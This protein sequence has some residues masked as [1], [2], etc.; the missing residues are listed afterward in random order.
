MTTTI[1]PALLE[2]IKSLSLPLDSP[3]WAELSHAFGSAAE[4]PTDLKALAQNEGGQEK[5]W[6]ELWT[7]LCHQGTVYTASFA[8][9]PH[10]VEM[11]LNTPKEDRLQLIVLVAMIERG[12]LVHNGAFLPKVSET[13]YFASL[14][15]LGEIILDCL[16][17]IW[18]ESEYKA[19]FMSLATIRGEVDLG[20]AIDFLDK[21]IQCP[22]CE[23][24]LVMDNY[25][26]ADVVIKREG[27]REFIDNGVGYLQWCEDHPLGFIVRVPLETVP[28]QYVLHRV[29]CPELQTEI[30]GKHMNLCYMDSNL[31]HTWFYRYGIRITGNVRCQLCFES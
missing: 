10:L 12:R 17:T 29:G 9:V 31:I 15:L 21:Q 3:Q 27:I 7:T 4:T 2:A 26:I 13:V 6:S 16:Q 24:E 18:N 1:N 23:T 8:A 14:A 11:A 22:I 25:H 30:T 20:W 5:T 28:L 19:L